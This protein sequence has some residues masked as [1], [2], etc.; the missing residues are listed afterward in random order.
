MAN[1]PICTCTA[2]FLSVYIHV[3][4]AAYLDSVQTGHTALHVAAQK[5][6]LSVVEMLLEANA[7][8]SIKTNVR[9]FTV[10]TQY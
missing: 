5:G 1:V 10:C 7:D 4:P 6:H 3:C 8:V 9:S 2:T